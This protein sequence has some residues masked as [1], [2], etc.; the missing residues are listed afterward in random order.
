MQNGVQQVRPTRRKT[1]DARYFVLLTYEFSS[2]DQDKSGAEGNTIPLFSGLIASL[3][4]LTP[5]ASRASC[6]S[7]AHEILSPIRNPPAERA[8]RKVTIPIIPVGLEITEKS[9]FSA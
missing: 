8:I 2:S 9:Q 1:T 7:L 3:S 5:Y 6:N 4:G